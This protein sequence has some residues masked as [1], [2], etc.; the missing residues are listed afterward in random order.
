MSHTYGIK[1][2]AE[3][4]RDEAPL[5]SKTIKEWCEWVYPGS[6]W[7]IKIPLEQFTEEIISLTGEIEPIFES[8][9]IKNT[10]WLLNEMIKRGC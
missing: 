1:T 2:V 3:I 7:E 6:Q 10:N 5:V 4:A 8:Y 9:T